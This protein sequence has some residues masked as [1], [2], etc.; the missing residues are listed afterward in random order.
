MQVAARF[1]IKSEP[2]Y[3]MILGTIHLFLFGAGFYLQLS[4]WSTLVLTVSVVVSLYFSVRHYQRLTQHSDDLC[5]SGQ[6][7]LVVETSTPPQTHYLQLDEES[8]I[9]SF[10]CLLHFTGTNQ[11]YCWLFTR[12]QLGQRAYS[13]LCFIA[14]QDLKS[15]KKGLTQTPSKD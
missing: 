11:S 7:W 3:L 15:R 1:P 9:S 4:L 12:H 10:A 13:Q 8:W 6:N 14:K 5:W 2:R